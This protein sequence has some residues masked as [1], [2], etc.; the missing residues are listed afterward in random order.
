MQPTSAAAAIEAAISAAEA[1]AAAVQFVAIKRMPNPPRLVKVALETI[2]V[3]LQENV[4]DWK[5]IQ[6]V[7]MLYKLYVTGIWNTMFDSK[8]VWCLLSKTHR[9]RSR[10]RFNLFLYFL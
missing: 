8:A 3:L 6:A 2:C 7:A 5:S 10:S 4:T 9:S 1:A